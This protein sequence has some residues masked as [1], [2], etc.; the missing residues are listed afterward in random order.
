MR[1]K[2]AVSL[3]VFFAAALVWTTF[4]LRP[5][6]GEAGEYYQ[7]KIYIDAQP[8]G[9]KSGVSFLQKDGQLYIS[10]KDAQD[11]FSV[12]VSAN[13]QKSVKVS[14]DAGNFM[15][16][17][18]NGAGSLEKE[19]IVYLPFRKVAEKLNYHVMW[20]NGY[21]SLVSDP[22]AAGF[23]FSG[24]R[25]G[26]SE[27]KMIEYFGQ[28]DRKD[29]FSSGVV[30][31]LYAMDSKDFFM[32]DVKDG[33]VCAIYSN[34]GGWTNKD[35]PY[36]TERSQAEQVLKEKYSVD[37]S[38]AD[39]NEVGIGNVYLMFDQIDGNR[40]TAVCA[41]TPLM[42]D[43][44][45]PA[46]DYPVLE[47]EMLDILNAERRCRGLAPLAADKTVAACAKAHSADMGERN[48]FDHS[49]PDGEDIGD[50][51][52][53]QE[54]PFVMAGENI[55]AGYMNIIFAHSQLLN[56][57]EHRENL[58]G[59]F[60]YAGIGIAENADSKYRYY[61]TQNFYTPQANL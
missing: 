5:G 48:Y 60:Q 27:K 50:R 14:S 10:S 54:I 39:Q 34:S 44:M 20:E 49:N 29:T 21:L 1:K 6:T 52:K 53:K 35:L 37:I 56:S 40:L 9:Q 36:G 15:L 55:A 51:M 31:Y 33:V 57:P 24:I 26:S 58:L 22:L 23:S 19:G 12:R 46:Q 11:L 7:A 8:A 2:I 18:D 13:A 25:F 28:P 32:A 42:M 3:C 61:Y 30:R 16:T 45:D 47:Q 41:G 17:A 59:D 43:D 4:Q 38:K